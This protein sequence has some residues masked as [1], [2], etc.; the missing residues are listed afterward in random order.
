L[1]VCLYLQVSEDTPPKMFK[2]II[3]PPIFVDSRKSV[4]DAE[5]LSVSNSSLDNLMK[6]FRIISYMFI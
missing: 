5:K 4:K 1:V 6:S 2:S 3:S